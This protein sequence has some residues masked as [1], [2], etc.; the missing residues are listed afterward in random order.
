MNI[1]VLSYDPVRAAQYTCDK[2]VVKMPLETA[3]LLC[4][5]FPAGTAPYKRTHYNHPCAQWVRESDANYRWLCLYGVHIGLEYTF[6]YGRKHKSSEVI[7]W[8]IK[9][10]VSNVP[11]NPT[12][13]IQVM[14]DEHKCADTVAAYRNYYRGDKKAMASWNRGRS[15]P[16][17]WK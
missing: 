16:Y 15:A 6:R 11:A 3:Q 1:F 14:P 17:W 10:G 12:A 9:N 7:E 4:S 2:H 8:C 5:V 13:F